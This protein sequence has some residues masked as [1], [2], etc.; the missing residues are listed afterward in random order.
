MV[1]ASFREVLYGDLLH[2]PAGS[3]LEMILFKSRESGIMAHDLGYTDLF[4]K[5]TRVR[6]QMRVLEAKVNTND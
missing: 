3:E 5:L 6:E 1:R 2:P 4:G